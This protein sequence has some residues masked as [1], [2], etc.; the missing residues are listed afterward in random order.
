MKILIISQL[1]KDGAVSGTINEFN[2]IIV[3][4]DK[5]R[6]N[7]K[8]NYKLSLKYMVIGKQVK[9]LLKR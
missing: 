2:H 7:K 8:S 1:I 4:R 6:I 5:N 9:K 3:Y